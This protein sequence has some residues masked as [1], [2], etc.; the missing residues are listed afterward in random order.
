MSEETNV[1][2][3]EHR[4]TE[5]RYPDYGEKGWAEKKYGR[6][7]SPGDFFAFLIPIAAVAVA[8]YVWRGY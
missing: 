1:K 8:M 6:E 5:G 3:V 4:K 2:I 7:A